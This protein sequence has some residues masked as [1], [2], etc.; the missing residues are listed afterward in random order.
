M[1]KRKEEKKEGEARAN[2][3]KKGK[4]KRPVKSESRNKYNYAT[5]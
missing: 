3:G 4:E 5:N 2:I 1:R